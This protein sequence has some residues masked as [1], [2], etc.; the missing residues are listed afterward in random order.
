[1]M[2]FKL[3]AWGL[4]F[5]TIGFSGLNMVDAQENEDKKLAGFF[6]KML[7]DEFRLRP[8]VATQLG[9]HRFDDK[10]E[11]PSPENQQ[12]WRQFYKSSLEKLRAQINV[13]F[14]S[15]I[16]VVDFKVLESHLERT[17]WT[18]ENSKTYENDPRAYNELISDSLYLPLSQSTIPEGKVID[19][20]VSR[21][22]LV[23]KVLESAKISLKNP[24]K[25]ILNTAIKQNSGSIRFYKSGV[26]DFV[27]DAASKAKLLEATNKI[28]PALEDY[29]DFLQG[30]AKKSGEIDWRIGREKFNEKLVH[31]LQTGLGADELLRLAELEMVTITQEMYVIARQLWSGLYPDKPLPVPDFKGKN[32][33]IVK[34]LEKLG[35]RRGNPKDLLRDTR[36]TVKKIQSFITSKNIL[37]LP[38]PDRC[39]I[40]EMPEFQRGNSV[41]YLNQAPPLDT[42]AASVYAIS[43]PPADWDEST[44]SSFMKEY[45]SYMLQILTI[46]EAYPGHYVQLEYSNKHP[47]KIR[48]VLSSG[49]F[50]EG[51]AVYTEKMMLDEGYGDQDLGLRIH[52]LKW[53]LRAV[54][55][56]VLDHQMHCNK[57]TDDEA[58]DLLV[59]RA[60][61][62]KGEA[63]GKIIRSKQSS[64]QLS[65]YFAGAVFFN[66]LRSDVQNAKGEAFSLKAYHEAVLSHGTLPLNLLRDLVWSDLGLKK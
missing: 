43:P 14:L 20:L 45:N 57:M 35:E 41:A 24:P 63:L 51:W 56:A 46:H 58:L 33:T 66:K 26:G 64:C 10:L 30:L 22:A 2:N 36:S 8:M 31:E 61:Q 47:S 7:E 59:N 40:L 48:R 60:F 37:A 62:T 16:G 55:N 6:D 52:Q 12:A 15:P 49:V 29:Q 42:N 11:N 19:A 32:E 1:M 44:V 9:D 65:T 23:P 54:A 3:I 13:K 27:K 39:Q 38:Q 18:M 21:V 50:A 4:I 5:L 25:I 17:V 34:V 28:V 53:Y